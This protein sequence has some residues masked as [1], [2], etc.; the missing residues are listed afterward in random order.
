VAETLAAIVLAGGASRRMGRDK[1]SLVLD[2]AEGSTLLERTVRAARSA[3]ADRIVVVGEQPT[4]AATLPTPAPT[5]P[6]PADVVFVREDPP[7][8]GPVPALDTALTAV[9][10]DWVLV[11][12]CDLARPL[13]AAR[14]LVRA[15]ARRRSPDG[16]VA[17]DASGRRQHL[18]AL[19]RTAALRRTADP[20]A[21]AMRAR[22]AG[23][24]LD[25]VPET[26]EAPGLWDDMDT[27]ADLAAARTRAATGE[28]TR[29]AKDET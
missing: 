14:E 21:T 4:G 20:A 9:E 17:V 25:E 1:A 12:P 27:P 8:S 22:M 2:P 18:T 15:Q 26:A 23:L 3:G 11:L 29:P 19:L 5:G 24:E 7:R 10:A 6:S 13:E 16:V 28:A